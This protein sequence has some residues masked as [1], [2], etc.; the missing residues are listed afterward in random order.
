MP[1]KISGL[2]PAECLN[3]RKHA[4]RMSDTKFDRKSDSFAPAGPLEVKKFL[5]GFLRISCAGNCG[6]RGQATQTRGAPKADA[7]WAAYLLEPNSQDEQVQRPK[8]T[9]ARYALQVFLSR[10]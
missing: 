9:D 4:R 10:A 3:A 5:V 2:V 7:G 1:E 8:C 6:T